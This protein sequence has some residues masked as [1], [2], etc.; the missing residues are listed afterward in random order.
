MGTLYTYAENT[1]AL[2]FAWPAFFSS[3]A[4]ARELV[5]IDSMPLVSPESRIVSCG[6]CFASEIFPIFSAFDIPTFFRHETCLHFSAD[7]LAHYLERLARG[8]APGRTRF[9]ILPD[10]TV[11][12]WDYLSIKKNSSDLD[13]LHNHLCFLDEIFIRNIQTCTQ[14]ILTLGAANTVYAVKDGL[15]IAKV[16]NMRP[17]EYVIRRQAVADVAHDI[18]RIFSAM[19]T[20]RGGR[21]LTAFLSVSPQRYKFPRCGE[22]L[23]PES[24][25]PADPL[26]ES[27]LS[28][29][30]LQLAAESYCIGHGTRSMI[31][32]F[33]S[34]NIVVD[35]LR[36]LD[37]FPNAMRVNT[38]YTVNHVVKRFFQAYANDGLRQRISHVSKIYDILS[39]ESYKSA[40][41]REDAG[42]NIP[43]V[44]KMAFA[45]RN[46]QGAAMLLRES[47]QGKRIACLG[48]GIN[49][50]IFVRPFLE[51]LGIREDTSYFD[52]MT[53][54]TDLRILPPE[55]A[56]FSGFDLV[57]VSSSALYDIYQHLLAGA[58]A[59]W[60]DAQ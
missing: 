37:P 15:P 58:F 29:A 1:D 16:V 17:E 22:A 33:P 38:P 34:Y 50:R 7:S 46:P 30:V 47:L 3:Y 40:D 35:E 23:K 11:R 5:H 42:K 21:P 19:D 52:A 36:S 43:C 59:V 2:H 56:D 26:V 24:I 25:M 51:A 8:E 12:H 27:S 9:Q 6:S 41:N 10:G 13:E 48:I 54:G 53:E 31:V 60:L 32:Y 20:L 18:A 39:R 14:F 44:L 55:T 57:I 45:C 28:K 49:F 4:L